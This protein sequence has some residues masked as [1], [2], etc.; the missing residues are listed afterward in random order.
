MFLLPEYN[1]QAVGIDED[2]PLFG[3]HHSVVTED[4]TFVMLGNLANIYIL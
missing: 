2:Y 1:P 4:L 3:F